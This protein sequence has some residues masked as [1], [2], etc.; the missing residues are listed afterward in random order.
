MSKL[1]KLDQASQHVLM[2]VLK[3]INTNIIDIQN[4]NDAF[5]VRYKNGNMYSIY[6]NINEPIRY[7]VKTLLDLQN[8]DIQIPSG[9]FKY[10]KLYILLMTRYFV[11]KIKWQEQLIH[12]NNVF[13]N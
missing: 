8:M 10:F 13:I 11:M 12:D 3:D 7:S 2:H 6:D 1:H 4:I 9:E 5:Y